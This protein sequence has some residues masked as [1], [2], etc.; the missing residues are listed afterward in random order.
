MALSTCQPLREDVHLDA[1]EVLLFDNCRLVHGRAPFR[2]RYDGTDRWLRKA[3]ATADLAR[4]RAR[5]SGPRSA[6]SPLFPAGPADGP[7]KGRSKPC[8]PTSMNRH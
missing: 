3:V 5:R 6:G 2:P 1:G 8:P 7:E 4:T